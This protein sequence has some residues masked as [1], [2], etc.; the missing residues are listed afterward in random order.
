MTDNRALPEYW[1]RVHFGDVVRQVKETTK[2]PGTEGFTRIV[3][4]DHLD[5]ESL[6]LRRWHE[7]DDLPDGTSFTR[8][9]RAGQVLFGKRRRIN[10]R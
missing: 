7:L 1:R 9:F 8:I 6:R 2:D 3:G 4:L 10:G 5:S